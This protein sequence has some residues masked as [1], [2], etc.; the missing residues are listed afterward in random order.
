[1]FALFRVTANVANSTGSWIHP[2]AIFQAA[3]NVEYDETTDKGRGAK[4]SG[5]PH[6]TRRKLST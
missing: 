5:V 3:G 2:D 1:M 4:S 6:V